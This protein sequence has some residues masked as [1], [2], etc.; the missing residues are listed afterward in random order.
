[1]RCVNVAFQQYGEQIKEFQW[2][3]FLYEKT[4]KTEFSCLP[5][6][7][8][9]FSMGW[10]RKVDGNYSLV[11]EGGQLL[12]E[13]VLEVTEYVKPEMPKTVKD[14]SDSTQVY[15]MKIFTLPADFH[16]DKKYSSMLSG[17]IKKFTKQKVIEVATWYDE[18]REKL[19]K[20]YRNLL[21]N[22]FMAHS[23]FDAISKWM[24]QGLP[25]VKSDEIDYRD[26]VC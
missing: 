24:T 9:F 5:E 15:L 3:M 21:Y 17:L 13:V 20:A 11:N 1:M 22:Q 7:A 6:L 8:P 12:I 4:G 23:I 16:I 18:N 19:P 10:L 2:L 25:E 14:F 26:R